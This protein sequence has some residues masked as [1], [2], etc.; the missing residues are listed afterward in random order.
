VAAPSRDEPD[1]LVV[2]RETIELAYLAA[3]QLLPPNQ[4]AVLILRDVLGW[5]AAETAALLDTSVASVTSALQRARV[6]LKDNR[7]EEPAEWTRQPSHPPR[8]MR[9]CSA[10]WTPIPAQTLPRWSR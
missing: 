7:P 6:T 9:C 8:S 10:T 5:S 3:I 2:A 1:A 4:R